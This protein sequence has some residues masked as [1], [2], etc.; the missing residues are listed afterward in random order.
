MDLLPKNNYGYSEFLGDEV[1]FVTKNIILVLFISLNMIMF[2]SCDK[3]ENDSDGVR[4]VFVS[5]PQKADSRM[6]Q[7]ASAIKDTDKEALKLLFS[8]MRCAEILIFVLCDP[9]DML[10]FT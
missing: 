7:I 8:N 3:R 1:L 10:K 4:G 6:Q 9:A 2:G 5:G